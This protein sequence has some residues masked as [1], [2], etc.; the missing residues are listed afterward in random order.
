MKATMTKS[1]VEV[2]LTMTGTQAEDLMAAVNFGLWW[3]QGVGD[4]LRSTY[5]ALEKAGVKCPDGQYVPNTDYPNACGYVER[6]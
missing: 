3:D 5:Y 1:E 4:V 2:T 6:V